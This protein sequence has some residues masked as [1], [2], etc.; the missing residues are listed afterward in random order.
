MNEAPMSIDKTI[1]LDDLQFELFLEK[2]QIKEAVKKIADQINQEYQGKEVL[3]LGVLDGAFMV[4][5][6]LLK[7]LDLTISLELVK[8]KS[9][10]GMESTGEVQKLL[11]LNSSLKDCEVIIVEDI[12][13][14]GQTLSYLLK[15][16]KDQ[17]PK[18][19]KIASL[20]LKADVFNDQFPVDYVGFSI[21]DKFVVGYGMDYKGLGR[22]LKHI[23]I[24]KE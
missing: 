21:P 12:I 18:S 19:V 15:L 14:T 6:D 16:I 11:G 22:Q 10:H 8:L 3:I 1:Q 4:L 17:Q 24:I 2:D 9:Y 5:S 20:L 23:Y 7:K 13:D